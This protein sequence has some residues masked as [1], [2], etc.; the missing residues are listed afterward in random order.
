[1]NNV[2][3]DFS[4]EVW[5]VLGLPFDNYSI[6]EVCKRIDEYIA[7]NS[8]CVLS[9]PNLNWVILSLNG[10]N[11]RKAVINSDMST[12]DSAIVFWVA[13]LLKIPLKESVPGSTLIQ[14]IL[15]KRIEKEYRLFF[16]GGQDGAARQ[17]F[18]AVNSMQSSIRAVGYY[19]PG[20]ESVESMS[21]E[22]TLKRINETKPNIV[23]V[24][25]GAKK[26]MLWIEKNKSKIK[27]QV[28]S[29]IGATVNFISG[30]IKRAPLWIQKIGIEWVWRIWQEP[31]LIARYFKDG[32]IFFYLVIT[33]I[34][35]Y[36][37][38]LSLHKKYFLIKENPIISIE[39][40]H[41]L[42]KVRIAGVCNYLNS[43]RTKRI[44]RETAIKNKDVLIDFSETEHI[45]NSFLG[46]LLLLFK[47]KMMQNRKLIL[48][49]VNR[50]LRKIFRRNLCDFL[51]STTNS[52]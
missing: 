31:K 6:Q 39:E 35:P 43:E 12:I 22:E 27:A 21:S 14:Y 48:M 51:I 2:D 16:F 3:L 8:Q 15:S 46:F 30:K 34:F 26:G 4:R 10:E 32:V 1:M 9:T 36:K 11:F 13:K 42:L 28:I 5:C 7:H 25:L 52:A 24:S 47:Y 33:Y 44:F 50:Q 20:I 23:L 49:N 17:A 41:D 45:D 29:H 40:E 19:E 37:L 18:L 38:L